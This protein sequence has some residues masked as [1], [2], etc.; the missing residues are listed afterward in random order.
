MPCLV[1]R[2]YGSVL[3]TYLSRNVTLLQIHTFDAADVQF[4]DA[5]V[6]SAV[7]VF[8]SSRWKQRFDSPVAFR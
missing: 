4:A 3:R 5:L 6:S 8:S 7:V 2:Y 1:K